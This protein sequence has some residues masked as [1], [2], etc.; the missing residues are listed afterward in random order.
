[1]L[2]PETKRRELAYIVTIDEIKPIPNYDRV[3]HARVNGWWI[4]V[5]KD[6]FKVGDYAIYIEVDSKTPEKE[7]FMFLEKKHFKVKTQK[8]CK[9]LSQGL[10]MSV[11]DFTSLDD[12]PQWAVDLQKK[13]DDGEDVTNTFLTE[14]LGLTYADAEDNK[15]KA[16]SADKYKKMAQR[17]GKLFSKQPFRWLMR[18]KWGKKLLFI[19]FGKAKDKKGGWPA[20]VKKTDEERVQNMPW[21]LEDKRPL[22]ATEKVDGTSTTFSMRKK[23]KLFGRYK[24]EFY[25][26]SRNVV[27]DT[28]DRGCY[29]DS[30]VYWEMAKKYDIENVLKD[31]L[32]NGSFEWVTLQGETFGDGIQKRGYL[33]NGAHDFRAFNLIYS[34]IGRVNTIVMQNVLAQY[35]IPCVPIIDTNY[36]LPDTVD[37]LLEY[38]D[39]KSEIDGGMREG[40]VF[41]DYKGNLSFKAV[42][43]KFLMKYH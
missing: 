13:I 8:M 4:I 30:N 31:I 22:I 18:R 25:V 9:V 34:T 11:N 17:H 5:K 24:Y 23:K 1:M 43:N 15:R 10:L 38:A 40:I 37:E 27:Q 35:N 21:V 39:G 32:N 26:C 42:S 3:E 7:P 41:R 28:P 19:F 33:K 20:W 36:I 6:Q 16:N 29:Y 12:A 2:N 14:S